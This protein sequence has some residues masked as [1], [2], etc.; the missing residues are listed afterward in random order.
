MKQTTKILSFL[1]LIASVCVPTFSV[2][3]LENDNDKFGGYSIE[4]VPHE[5][6]LDST[7]GY[8]YLQE[9]PGEKDEIRLKLI[10]GSKTNKK[11]KIEV[12][13]SNT[14]VNGIID[15]SNKIKPHHTLKTP[16]TS[17]LSSK[18][19]RVTVPPESTV[20]TTFSIDMPIQ[21]QKGV[22]IGGI[23]VSED[24]E[25]VNNQENLSLGNTY[26]YTM[27][28][29]LTNENKIEMNKNVSV[30][31]EKVEPKLY[32][33]RKIVQAD[34]LNPN[35]YLFGSAKVTGKI[36]E[37]DSKDLVKKEERQNVNI[38]PYSFFPFQ[39]DWQKENLKP[40]KY[41][42]KG[43]VETKDNKWEFEKEFEITSEKAKEINNESVFKVQ[44]PEWLTYTTLITSIV[45]IVGTVWLVV[46]KRRKKHE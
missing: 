22:I 8:Y 32:D 18:E 33:G 17:I 44:I 42:F 30:E 15:Y 43:V 1:F 16:L 26:S 39:I 45:T 7:V 28:V 31:L 21:K 37:K 27:G 13:N 20:E 6:Q 5:K 4:G 10:N 35:P 11:L 14:N 40:G 19:S 25:Q 38:A 46:R 9:N 36:L 12:T 41:I 34:I 2:N 29:V 23:V 3:A 24:K